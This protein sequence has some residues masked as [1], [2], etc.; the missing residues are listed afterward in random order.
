MSGES[1]LDAPGGATNATGRSG[2]AERLDQFQRRHPLVAFP[3]A[4][5]Y[6]FFDD[7]GTYL[8]ALVTY[9]G[10]LSL[11]PLLL[12]FAS[13]LGFVLQGDPDLQRRILDSTL[14]QF[15]IIGDQ[16]R[17]PQSLRGS[18]V[19][20]VVGGLTAL[21]G[22][23]GVAQATQN[24]MNVAWA[25]PRHRRPNPIKSRVRSLFLIG[26]A[27]VAVLATTV[28]SALATNAHAYG[29][30][31]SRLAAVGAAILAVV[32]NVVVLVVV[33]RVS[34]A[35]P[36]RVRDVLP[37]AI[38]AAVIWQVLQLTGSTYVAHVL[39]GA[40]TTYGVFALVLGLLAWIFLAA[41][42]LVL[43]VE[44]NVVRAKRLYPRALLTP[45][46]DDVDLTHGDRQAYAAAAVA[47]R[48]KSFESVEVSFE[49]GGQNASA[50]RQASAED[51]ADE[52]ADDE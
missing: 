13:I 26:F 46:T 1:A 12:L 45:F 32:V 15:P 20:V 23:L 34:T 21:Y 39:K 30:D 29:A 44:I 22:A 50:R 25:V 43:S 36:L 38:T 4:V 16:L 40:G 7:Q 47:Q 49:H 18:T 33:F 17:E 11:F 42:A 8:A 37:G 5:V 28:L 27:G 10:F 14:S 35:H 3:I 48:Y 9:Y 41:V 19:A 51:Q 31:I 2:V 6:K 52:G 24:A